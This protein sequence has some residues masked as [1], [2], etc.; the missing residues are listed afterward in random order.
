MQTPNRLHRLALVGSL[1]LLPL[2]GACG[3]DDAPDTNATS[4]TTV[5]SAAAA[6]SDAVTVKDFAFNPKAVTVKAGTTV[7]WTNKDG[8]EH[9]VR[10]DSLDVDGDNFGTDATFTHQFDKAG[11]F[12]YICG[13]H[14]SMTGSV[15]VTS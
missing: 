11:T 4:E 12:P 2:L 13:V 8:F 7:T 14:N 15:I 5:A 6:T 10:I 9:S 1:A 3:G